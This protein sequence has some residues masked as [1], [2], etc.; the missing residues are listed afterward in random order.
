MGSNS[1]AKT[2]SL[3]NPTRCSLLQNKVF[4]TT[5]WHPTQQRR[6]PACRILQVERDRERDRQKREREREHILQRTSS[7]DDDLQRY[8]SY[9]VFVC[10]RERQGE[11]ERTYSTQNTLRTSSADDD[12]QLVNSYQVCVCLCVLERERTYSTENTLR[13]RSTDDDV[14]AC[15]LLPEGCVRERE[16]TFY[17]THFLYRTHSTHYTENIFYREH[18]LQ[19]MTKSVTTPNRCV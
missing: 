8:K 19:K 9:Q 5:E 6:L 2:S 11:R 15:Q 14:A 13:T 7:I 10:E 16:S 1:A 3:S 17:G 18:I 12:L 4:F